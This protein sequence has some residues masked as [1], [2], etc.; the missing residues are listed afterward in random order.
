MAGSWTLPRETTPLSRLLSALLLLAVGSALLPAQLAT[1]DLVLAANTNG[2]CAAILGG[3]GAVLLR[4]PS[5]PADGGASAG[6]ALLLEHR[7]ARGLRTEF[8]GPGQI[9]EGAHLELRALLAQP[10]GGQPH[11]GKDVAI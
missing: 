6:R 11:A 9:A 7:E 4:A 10:F 1:G 5:G 3:A 8:G 2:P